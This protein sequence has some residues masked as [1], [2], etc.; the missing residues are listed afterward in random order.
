M[1]IIFS[2]LK[3]GDIGGKPYDTEKIIAKRNY[4]ESEVI[5]CD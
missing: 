4:A 3:C 1:Y 2:F 5:G